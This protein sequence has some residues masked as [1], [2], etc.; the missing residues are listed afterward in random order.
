[1]LKHNKLVYIYLQQVSKYLQ[2]H[3]F[4]AT[5]VL[6]NETCSK[7]KPRYVN[8]IKTLLSTY[9]IHPS[10]TTFDIKMI[11]FSCFLRYAS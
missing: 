5:A 6:K 10:F 11:E 7:S 3:G 1:M 4:L 2:D 8:A 9:S